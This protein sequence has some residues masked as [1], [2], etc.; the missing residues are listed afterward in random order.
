MKKT[1]ISQ[2]KKTILL[3]PLIYCAF[4]LLFKL[5]FLLVK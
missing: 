3:P 2:L 1:V 4:G 5:R